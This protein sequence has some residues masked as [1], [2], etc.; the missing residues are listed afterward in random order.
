MIIGHFALA[1]AVVH[2]RPRA[3]LWW[4]LPASIAPDLLD[5]G[6]AFCGICNPYGLYSHTLPAAIL[7]GSVLAGAAVL[8]GRRETAAMILLV[9]LLHLPLDYVT[10][11][12]LFWPGGQMYGLQLYD[13]PLWDFLLE[14][15]LLAG[16]WALLRRGGRG[17]KWATSVWSLAA[18]VVLQGGVDGLHNRAK[19]PNSCARAVSAS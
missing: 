2:A 11:R 6:Y 18:L 15:S 14:S 19:K 4:L 5:I 9:V 17:P 7:L 3:S 16:G 1:A 13:W 10:G 8:A 12:K